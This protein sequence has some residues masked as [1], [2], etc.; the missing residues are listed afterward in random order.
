MDQVEEVKSKVDIVEVISSHG[1]LKKMGR[2]FA[3][4]C[5]FHSEK[6]PSFMVSPE[7][8]SF[9][10]F[11][12]GEGGDVFTFLEKIE[13]WDFREAL[14]EIAKRVGVKLV[15]QGLSRGSKVREKLININ[16]LTAK[17]YSH[18]LN[19][20]K[21]GEIARQYLLR[22]GVEQ[23]LWKKFDLGY[24]PDGWENTF[25]FLTKRGFD[26]PDIALSGLVIG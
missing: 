26:A 19:S 16:S 23:D 25:N 9:K 3:G 4:L 2:N 20:H 22:R 14:E 8:Q 5:P 12:C 6:T 17:F 10:C 13:G 15:N 24:S 11:G 1:P 18:I 21:L 7:R